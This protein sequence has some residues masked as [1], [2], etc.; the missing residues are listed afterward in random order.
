M[1]KS[2]GL[3]MSRVSRL[4]MPGRI[5]KKTIAEDMKGVSTSVWK[6]NNKQQYHYHTKV[7]YYW[8]VSRMYH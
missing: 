7:E 3:R 1:V 4:V 2:R 5:G 8:V 6:S